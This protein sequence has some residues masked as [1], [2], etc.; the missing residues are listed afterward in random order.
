MDSRWL[1]RSVVTNDLVIVV[2]TPVPG[3]TWKAVWRGLTAIMHGQRRFRSDVISVETLV[4]GNGGGQLA[5]AFQ[6]NRWIIPDVPLYEWQH[7][8]FTLVRLGHTSFDTLGNIVVS[9][10]TFPD[11]DPE[12]GYR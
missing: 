9:R 7:D 6:G 11:A 5:A 4:D 10:R 2:R 12:P 3:P 1:Y 8:S